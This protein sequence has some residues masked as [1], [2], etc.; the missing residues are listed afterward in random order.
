MDVVEPVSRFTSSMAKNTAPVLDK[1][2]LFLLG[3]LIAITSYPPGKWVEE[4]LESVSDAVLK[5]ID[6]ITTKLAVIF[7][8][9]TVLG[10][11][12]V[13]VLG[14]IGAKVMVKILAY[15]ITILFFKLIP[16]VVVSFAI[17]TRF[18]VYLFDIV[19]LMLSIPFYAVG[20]VS[21]NPSSALDFF[22]QIA[23]VLIY[24]V[25]LVI[26]P[27]IAFLFFEVAFGVYFWLLI[28]IV[29]NVIPDSWTAGFY[30][31]LLTIVSYTI[32]TAIASYYGWHAGY[33]L[34][35]KAMEYMMSLIGGVSSTIAQRFEGVKDYLSQ[36]LKVRL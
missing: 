3:Q 7:S 1:G 18:L 12:A 36:L 22:K 5:V 24:P 23:K 13:S 34:P 26:V 9:P 16:F 27:V 15:N 25:I 31:G 2:A 29:A 6:K 14:T 10:L 17:L 35:E 30:F 33:V 11:G 19:A 8:G 32:G 21:K 28:T 4:A 20:A